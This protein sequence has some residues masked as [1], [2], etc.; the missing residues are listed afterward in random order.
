M[1]TTTTT[2]EPDRGDH[3]ELNGNT[4]T[5]GVETTNGYSH[6]D[7]KACFD[8][9]SFRDSR[10]FSCTDW[11][12]LNCLMAKSLG[13][14]SFHQSQITQHCRKSC[15]R[16]TGNEPLPTCQGRDSSTYTTSESA[17]MTCSDWGGK[18]CLAETVSQSF[19]T[20][21]TRRLLESC[22]N[23]CGICACESGHDCGSAGVNEGGTIDDGTCATIKCGALCANEDGCGWSSDESQCVHGGFTSDDEVTSGECPPEFGKCS[24]FVLEDSNLPCTCLTTACSSCRFDEYIEECLE[25][26]SGTYLEGGKCVSEC[27]S[28]RIAVGST[29]SQRVCSEPFTCN[30]GHVNEGPRAGAACTCSTNCTTCFEDRAGSH[31][32]LCVNGFDLFQGACAA[33]CPSDADKIIVSTLGIDEEL[34]W[35]REYCHHGNQIDGG[36]C[37]CPV[38]CVECRGSLCRRCDDGFAFFDGFCVTDERCPAALPAATVLSLQG[39]TSFKECTPT[40]RQ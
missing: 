28:S 14:S 13:Y 30:A 7:G 11:A 8:Y 26:G 24:W 5:I 31:C 23:A 4:T 29:N 34:C 2:D 17:P 10:G 35:P 12:D 38:G 39:E 15:G 1:A 20:R 25:C 37:Q 3:G 9:T 19:T 36:V 32:S 21:E 33:E 6:L 16:C 22:P 18:L 27:S 40:I